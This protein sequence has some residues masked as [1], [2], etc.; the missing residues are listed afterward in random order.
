MGVMARALGFL[1]ILGLIIQVAETSPGA[2][3][4]AATMLIL[5]LAGA[6]VL[7]NPLILPSRRRLLAEKSVHFVETLDLSDAEALKQ[8]LLNAAERVACSPRDIEGF[9]TD[10]ENT[11]I[12]AIALTKIQPHLATL[13]RKKAQNTYKDDYGIVHEGGWLDECEYFVTR[14]L[15]PLDRVLPRFISGKSNQY[16][17]LND[18]SNS[19]TV[20]L[21][22]EFIND[23]V[24][25]DSANAVLTEI[26]SMSGHDYEKFVANLI[27]ICGW[28]ALVTKGSGDQGADIITE[29]DGIRVVMQCKLY[30]SAV[31]NKAVQEVHAARAFYDCDYACVVS[32]ADYTPSAR[33]IAERTGVSLLHHDEIAEYLDDL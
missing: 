16:E 17:L 26:T 3:A 20:Q 6:Y 23:L 5:V 12:H 14:V 32:N 24:E 9:T 29:Q 4:L 22:T 13:R 8:R 21:W 15:L 27:E 7:V 18:T 28:K 33:K 19:G 11:L 30:S 10:V 31:G 1:L 2:F 25:Y